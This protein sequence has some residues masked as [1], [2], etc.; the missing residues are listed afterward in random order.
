MFKTLALL[1]SMTLLLPLQ[2]AEYAQQ[3][4][5]SQLDCDDV[6]KRRRLLQR[7]LKKHECSSTDELLD[8][9]KQAE[10]GLD[11]W[12]EL[13]G[14]TAHIFLAVADSIVEN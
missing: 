9:A 6:S 10:A 3:F 5:F 12:F 14:E 8:R 7:L 2:I 13:E 4:S 11:R 1:R